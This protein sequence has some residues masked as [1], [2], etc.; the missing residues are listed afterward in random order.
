VNGRRQ[1]AR[2][3]ENLASWKCGVKMIVVDARTAFQTVRRGIGKSLVELYRHL[4][5]LRP[6]WRFA[7]F[8]RGADGDAPFAGLSNVENRQIE[9]PGDRWAL[10]QRARLPFA[11]RMARADVLHCPANTGPRW[12]LVPMLLTIHDLIPLQAEFVTEASRKWGRNVAIAAHKAR[13]ITTPS[14][15]SKSQIASTFGIPAEKIAVHHWGPNPLCKP[16][17]DPAKLARIKHGYGVG[18]DRKYALAFGGEDPRKNTERVIRAWA[19]LPSRLRA[20]CSLVVVG[21]QEPLL[22]RLRQQCAADGLSQSCAMH[23]YVSENDLSDLLGGA[24]LLCYPSLSEG[25]GL[26]VLDAFAC[27]TAVVTSKVT[28]IPEIAGDAAYYVDPR[29]EREIADAMRLLLQD[30]AT[31]AELVEKGKQRLTMFSWRRCAEE[32]GAALE[33]VVP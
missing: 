21:V 9:M 7:M 19:C 24:S 17:V 3:W 32:F 15:Y 23:G 6:D 14:E 27:E 11:A 31:R 8:H 33:A 10:W 5:V 2:G 26:P 29:S 28:S 13:S 12:P 4:A 20:E 1:A 25:F 18:Q 16:I 30:S 22:A